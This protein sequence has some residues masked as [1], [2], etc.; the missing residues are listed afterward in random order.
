VAG[1]K[2]EKVI[3]VPKFDKNSMRFVQLETDLN[4]LEKDKFG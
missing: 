3:G 2:D 4:L 1:L